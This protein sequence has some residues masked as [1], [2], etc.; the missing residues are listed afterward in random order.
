MCGCECLDAHLLRHV[1]IVPSKPLE[2][3]IVLRVQS[4]EALRN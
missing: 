3:A 1:D 4:Q 2:N